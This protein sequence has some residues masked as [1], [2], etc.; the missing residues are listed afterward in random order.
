MISVGLKKNL[1]IISGSS[2]ISDLQFGQVAC[3]SIQRSK[4]DLWNS[5]LQRVMILLPVTC[6]R[7]IEHSVVDLVWLCVVV[8]FWSW[9]VVDID[10]ELSGRSA[11]W[12]INHVL[13]QR[14]WS[15]KEV[16]LYQLAFVDDV[17]EEHCTRSYHMRLATLK[18]PIDIIFAS[19][20]V[21]PKSRRV[22]QRLQSFSNSV[23]FSH[24]VTFTFSHLQGILQ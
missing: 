23:H 22:L 13:V 6:S 5:C 12:P 14:L 20:V 1:K 10:V 18:R 2:S 21:P 3:S 16:R 15:C 19:D 24:D 7:H 11:L 17:C 9:V 8:A 4:H